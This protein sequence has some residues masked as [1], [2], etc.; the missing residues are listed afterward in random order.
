MGDDCQKNLG[1]RQG[2]AKGMVRTVL[3]EAHSPGQL[4]QRDVPRWWFT[5]LDHQEATQY[6]R[7]EHGPAQLDALTAQG[8]TE[9]RSFHSS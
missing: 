2:V 7:I 1:G 9:K 3:G 8:G 4:T 5:A 6:S